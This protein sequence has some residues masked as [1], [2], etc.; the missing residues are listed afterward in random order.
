MLGRGPGAIVLQPVQQRSRLSEHQREQ[1]QQGE[2]RVATSV[3]AAVL[4]M[5]PILAQAPA[6]ST[7]G[8]AALRDGSLISRRSLG[9]SSTSSTPNTAAPRPRRRNSSA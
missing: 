3:Q 7:A 6:G 2:Q 9:I 4:D 1:R 5:G 8:P